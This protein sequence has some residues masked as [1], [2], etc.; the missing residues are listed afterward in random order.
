MQYSGNL[1][2]MKGELTGGRVKYT[3]TL[4][5]NEI[6]MDEL[7]NSSLRLQFQ[8]KINC[9][10]CGKQTRKSYGQGF[11]YQCFT[12]A[13][14]ADECVLKPDRCKAHLGISRDMEWSRE[15]CLQPHIVYLAVSG[16]LKVGVTRESQVPVRW[17][18]QGAAGAVPLCKTPNRHVAGVIETFLMSRFGDKTN[19]KKMLT[20]EDMS[21]ID[22]LKEKEKAIELLPAELLRYVQKNNDMLSIQYPVH[23]WPEIPAQINLDHEREVKG[24]LK[25]IRG[26]YLIFDDQKVLNIRRFSGYAVTFSF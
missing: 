17:I 7:L 12:T 4:G 19:W 18:D 14:E 8:G 26:Q 13:P 1:R 16:G 24:I 23:A 5:D 6:Q 20:N 3:L 9:I 15:H 25:G 22:L 21:R 10:L 2:K 11:C